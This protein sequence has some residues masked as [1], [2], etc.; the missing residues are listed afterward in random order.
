MSDS[1]DESVSGTGDHVHWVS[2]SSTNHNKQV[3]TA[4]QGAVPPQSVD[5]PARLDENKS[6]RKQLKLEERREK[7]ELNGLIKPNTDRAKL[8]P[9]DEQQHHITSSA[10][11][12]PPPVF[13]AR[14][15]APAVAGGRGVVGRNRMHTIDV[16]EVMGAKPLDHIYAG[17]NSNTGS[18][19][20]VAL[21]QQRNLFLE[22]VLVLPSFLLCDFITIVIFLDG[23]S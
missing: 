4:R 2:S 1:D 12:A 11:Q 5:P 17:Q 13:S 23:I 22:Q 6:Q 9:P 8:H 20:D 15:P 19:E 7:K 18:G 14:S 16:D 3:V 10:E 21:E